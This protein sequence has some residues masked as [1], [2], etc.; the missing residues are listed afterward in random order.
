MSSGI[1]WIKTW[2]SRGHL[3]VKFIL[4]EVVKLKGKSLNQDEYKEKCLSEIFSKRFVGY[5]D[6]KI[7]DCRVM[8]A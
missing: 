1:R 3:S 6:R 2:N 8:V 7:M 4:D 5:E